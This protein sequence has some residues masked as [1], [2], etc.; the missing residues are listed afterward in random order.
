MKEIRWRGVGVGVERLTST[1]SLITQKN[2]KKDVVLKNLENLK[3]INAK[4]SANFLM[5]LPDESIEILNQEKKE[6]SSILPMT[7]S[8]ISLILLPLPGTKIHQTTN[9]KRWYSDPSVMDWQPSYY[10]IVY[11]YFSN[12][13]HLNY[14]DLP[15]PVLKKMIELKEYFYEQSIKK[16]GS[17][18]VWYLFLCEKAL[19]KI[20]L[21]I[22]RWSPSLE[23]VI[24]SPIIFLR[25]RLWN[26]FVMKYYGKG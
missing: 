26:Y 18:I 24:F 9:K 4:T 12:A 20:S 25:N 21:A 8:V 13:I 5:G 1:V 10:H 2:S 16:V 23:R 14:F 7:S 17:N 15:A 6:F 11:N 19:A 22:Y 3:V